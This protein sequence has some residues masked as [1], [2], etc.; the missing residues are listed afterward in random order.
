VGGGNEREGGNETQNRLYGNFDLHK[1]QKKIFRTDVDH[2]T[3]TRD[4]R[5]MD[6][7]SLDRI[8]Q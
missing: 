6:E 2:A 8:T 3:S 4:G 5:E 1:I 7:F